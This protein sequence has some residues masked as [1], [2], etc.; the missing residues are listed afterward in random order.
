M[1]VVQF[2]DV[3]QGAMDA[4]RHGRWDHWLSDVARLFDAE[5]AGHVPLVAQPRRDIT[6]SRDLLPWATTSFR[7]HYAGIDPI[8]TAVLP[9]RGIHHHPAAFDP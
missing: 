3:A 9:D 5:M 4:A 8:H 6:T 2:D 7:D 1:S